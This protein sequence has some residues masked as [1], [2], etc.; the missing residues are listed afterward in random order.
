MVCQWQRRE[1]KAPQLIDEAK[2][3]DVA[4]GIRLKTILLL[5]H[6][7]TGTALHRRLLYSTQQG[8]R[9][10]GG[11]RALIGERA[12]GTGGQVL[13]RWWTTRS[14]WRLLWKWNKGSEVSECVCGGTARV[15]K[16]TH[17][18]RELGD[19]QVNDLLGP[20]NAATDMPLKGLRR[21][22]RIDHP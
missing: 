15:G 20:G 8:S 12:G 19:Q 6:H 22:L 9:V 4:A 16:G 7:S 13:C 1:T 2:R 3:P 14:C 11:A 18:L 17:T 10:P 5:L 21:S